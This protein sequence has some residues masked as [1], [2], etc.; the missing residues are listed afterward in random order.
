MS[1]L[2]PISF[3]GLSLVVSVSVVHA[4]GLPALDPAGFPDAIV[5]SPGARYEG[6]PIGMYVITARN[7][8]N[9]ALIPNAFVEIEFS[10]GAD[11]IVG[12]CADYGYPAPPQARG[13][14]TGVTDANGMASF[15]FYGGGCLDPTE[16]FGAAYEAQVRVNGLVGEEPFIN[17]PD[18]VNESGMKATDTPPPA[19]LKRCD[20]VGGV[21]TAQVSLSD[22]VFHTRPIKLGL[23]EPC[24]K[25]TP[26]FNG[27]VALADAVALTPYVKDGA[28]CHCQ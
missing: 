14:I 25:Y 16:Y 20:L 3:V 19:G 22:A 26:P 23:R 5:L 10:P 6:N 7:V 12:W 15:E 24:T 8:M 11:A 18:V 2:F 13:I 4:E 1:R 17:S 27:P 21:P 9:N 28:S